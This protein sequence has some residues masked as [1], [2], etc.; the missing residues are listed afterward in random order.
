M[1]PDSLVAQ[2]EAAPKPGRTELVLGPE[3]LAFAAGLA[4]LERMR[5][6]QRLKAAGVVVSDWWRAVEALV[7]A[8]R[9]D[10]E[11]EAP[12][13][14]RKLRRGEDGAPLATAANLGLILRNWPRMASLKLNQLTLEAELDGAPISGGGE[15]R[16]REDV[17]H[18]YRM[19][20]GQELM[21]GA[22]AAVAEERVYHPIRDYL[23]GLRWDGK[24]RIAFVPSQGMGASEDP[25]FGRMFHAWMISAVARM[26]APGCQADTCLVL[27]STK[28]GKGKS[29]FFDVLTGT[30][31]AW[32]ARGH[33]DPSEKDCAL[34]AH[35]LW[36]QVLDE[37]DDMTRRS[38][39]SAIKRWM[40]ECADLFRAPYAARPENYPRRFVFGGTTNKTEY[41]PA[42]SAA[43][44]RFSTIPVGEIDLDLIEARRDQ[45]WAEAR[46]DYMAATQ[47]NTVRPKRDAYVWWL[48]PEESE[49]ALALAADHQP[50][51]VWRERI[52]AWLGRRTSTE[53]P[54][55]VEIMEYGMKLEPPQYSAFQGHVSEAMRSLGY[56]PKNCTGFADGKQ[57][58][59]WVKG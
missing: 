9:A 11:G 42:E 53:P 4:E 43:A 19:I 59:A 14:Q 45:L 1:T 5:L 46:H 37:L 52:E 24:R 55:S 48:N 33:V 22:V 17:E 57:R 50:A 18:E 51:P 15:F 36:V 6:K 49:R 29:T 13:W 56:V 21:K 10:G 32:S 3:A 44:R 23:D 31:R 26:Y 20:A 25:L 12:E 47:N 58:K 28:G 34:K 40:T 54:T 2:V 38:E 27:Y 7:R 16:L 8:R 39:W 35:R 41:M 30:G